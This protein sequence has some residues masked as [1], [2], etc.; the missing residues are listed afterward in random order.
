MRIFDKKRKKKNCNFQ[1]ICKIL[2]SISKKTNPNERYLLEKI[3]TATSKMKIIRDIFDSRLFSDDQRLK[4]LT[5]LSNFSALYSD[6]TPRLH[7]NF[8]RTIESIT[9]LLFHSR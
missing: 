3:A 4:L 6:L 5:N 9:F 1:K 8:P 2:F 7:Q